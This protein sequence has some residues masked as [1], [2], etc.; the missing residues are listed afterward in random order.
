MNIVP[1]ATRFSGEVEISLKLAKRTRTIWMHGRNLVV[2]TATLSRPKSATAMTLR[3]LPAIPPRG[4]IGFE[5]PT[6]AGPGTATLRI[7]FRGGVRQRTGLFHQRYRGR[8]YAYTDLEPKDARRA[9]P[10]FDDPRFKVPWQIS[11]TTTPGNLAF[12]NTPELGRTSLPDGRVRFTFARTRPLPSYL[13]A[14]AVGPFEVVPATTKSSVP[15]RIIALHGMAARAAYAAKH[16]P[17]LLAAVERYFAMRAPYPKVDLIAVPYFAGAMENPGLITVGSHILLLPDQPSD[18]QRKMFTIVASHELAH[19]WFGDLV[20]VDY[21]NDLWLNEGFATWMS[22]KLVRAQAPDLG[23]RVEEVRNKVDAMM[24][25]R[26]HQRH[27]VRAHMRAHDRVEAAFDELTYKM[28]GALVTM[29]EARVGAAKFRRVLRAYVR[30]YADKV[31]SADRLFAALRNA[32]AGTEA[33]QLRRYVETTGFPLVSV[34]PRCSGHELQLS[35]RQQPYGTLAAPRS[36]KVTWDIPVCM[37]FGHGTHQHEHCVRLNK[38]QR[39][40]RVA[41][42]RCPTWLMPN[43]HGNGFYRYQLPDAWLTRTARSGKLSVRERADFMFNLTGLMRANLVTVPVLVAA[44]HGIARTHNQHTLR[45][46]M[47]ALSMLAMTTTTPRQ[48]RRFASLVRSL[49]GRRAR[50]LGLT[51]R[52]H[53]DYDAAAVRTTL[54]AFDAAYGHDRHV[55]ATARRRTTHWLRTDKGI[56]ERALALTVQVAGMAG[57]ARL[58]KDMTQGLDATKDL[59]ERRALARGLGS[60]LQPALRKRADALINNNQLRGLEVLEML[61][62]R[63][64]RPDDHAR[65]F[66]D[67]TTT[68]ASVRKRWPATLRRYLPLLFINGCSAG[69]LAAF[70][71]LFARPAIPLGEH[72]QRFLRM[73]ARVRQRIRECNTTRA[74]LSKSAARYFR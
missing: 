8:W 40:A 12:A 13:V 62:A 43:A 20:T 74:A 5:L 15:L 66:I 68:V 21:W 22:D 54:V 67:A 28:A 17:G 11:V 58:F 48:K 34:E 71:G 65:T 47:T 26:G 14:F 52:K 42:D 53:D 4:L 6:A 32:G 25:A 50:A 49:I 55:L 72:A 10:C 24:V 63:L 2:K 69:A 60:F 18:D 16:A 23:T 46:M 31:V 9:F 35:L 45:E 39:Q 1:A 44:L 57:D 33:A 29:I 3:S 36:H 70:N 64:L 38:P 56:H 41:V 37:R 61:E 19:L 30:K 59:T 27:P 73:R 7:A 51:R